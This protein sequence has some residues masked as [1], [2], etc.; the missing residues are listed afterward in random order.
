MGDFLEFVSDLGTDSPTVAPTE[1]TMSPTEPTQ[2]PLALL[3]VMA[4]NEEGEE[5][6]RVSKYTL[7]II[8]SAAAM[9]LFIA[10]VVMKKRTKSQKKMGIDDQKYM[11]VIGFL[12]Q[13]VDILSDLCFALQ[14]RAYR[15][16]LGE[17]EF[18][19]TVEP[20][21][22][23]WLY[24]FALIFTIGPY[25]LNLISSVNI[26][27]KMASDQ[28]LSEHSKQY[29]RAKTKVYAILVLMSGGAFPAL[30]MMSSNLLGLGLF[31]AGLSNIQLEHFRGHH[32]V[33]TVMLENVPQMALQWVFMFKLNLFTNV[34]IVSFINSI[35]NILMAFMSA[36]VFWI[37]HRNHADV[38]FT[39]TLKWK[40]RT[41]SKLQK[42]LNPY[43]QC[44]RRKKLAKLLGKIPVKGEMLKFEILSSTEQSSG[45]LL[46]GVFLSEQS[47]AAESEDELFSEFMGK[48]TEI[49]DAVMEAFKLTAF[50]AHFD[51]DIV[52]TRS[53]QM[54]PEKRLQL[55]VDGMRYFKV[56]DDVVLSAHTQMKTALTTG[57]VVV[58]DA[59]ATNGGTTVKSYSLCFVA[60][61]CSLSLPTHCPLTTE[62][63]HYGAT[64]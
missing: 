27:R 5:L 57:D 18:E 6:D 15:D 46:S 54:S 2:A 14:C 61:Q 22:F 58:E 19:V 63:T 59:I 12:L 35:L 60:V 40:Q 56:S 13:I 52:I 49:Q 28:S 11:S 39:I 47:I 32:V 51:F 31:S 48:Q 25:I 10:F 3:E 38:P 53:S 50:A 45:C 24:Y 29:F 16:H 20:V 23:E 37:L 26:T 1:P 8:G 55:I 4:Q 41:S 42:K 30:K 21:V 17:I 7:Y 9:M 33:T 64:E 34:V 36:A 62:S 44:G 43:S